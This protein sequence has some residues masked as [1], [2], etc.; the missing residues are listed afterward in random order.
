MVIGDTTDMMN[1]VKCAHLFDVMR[2][3]RPRKIL[4]VRKHEQG[5][6]CQPLQQT[7]VSDWAIVL[8]YE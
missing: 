6:S 4:F 5:R 2:G 7:T 3:Q 8:L 1:L